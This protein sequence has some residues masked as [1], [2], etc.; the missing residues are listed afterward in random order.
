MM[1]LLRIFSRE[2]FLFIQIVIVSFL[3][4]CTTYIFA[5]ISVRSRWI[6][7]SEIYLTVFAFTLT[8]FLLLNIDRSRSVY[9]LKWIDSSNSQGITYE[10]LE[11]IA[12]RESFGKQALNQ[13]LAEQIESGNIVLISSQHY[14]VTTRGH[15]LNSFFC[16]LANFTHLN[17]Y[18]RA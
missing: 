12:Y 15:L 7:G 8:S 11:V 5:R 3:L 10:E 18:K 14:S 16:F 9:L 1:G 4:L 13:R 2:T 17:G 6:L